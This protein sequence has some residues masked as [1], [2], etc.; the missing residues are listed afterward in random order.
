MRPSPSSHICAASIFSTILLFAIPVIARHNAAPSHPQSSQ[1]VLTYHVDNLRTGWFSSESQLNTSN[2]NPQS[3]GLLQ[4]VVLD[5]RVDAEPLVVMNQTI[6]GHG[7]HNVVYIATENNSVY[8]IDGDDGSILW[9]RAFGTPVPYQYKNSDDNVFPVMGILGTP[10]IDRV[11]GAMYFVS[12]KY[13]GKRDIFYLHAISLSTGKKLLPSVEIKF[14]QRLPSGKLWTLNPQVHLQRPGLLEVNGDLYIAF[15]STGDSDPDKSRG[16]ILRYDPATLTQLSGQLIN[17]LNKPASPYYLS[18]IWQSGYAPAAD[19]NGDVYFSTGNSDHHNPSYSDLNWPDSVVHLSGDLSTVVDSFTTHNYFQLDQKDLDTG[20][21]GT[22]LLPDQ[23]GSIPHL[24][25]A[26]GK[27]A[28][29]FLMNRDQLGSYTDNGPD[30][31]LQVFQKGACWCGPAYFVGSDGF[32]Y[33]VTGGRKGVISWQLQT[34]PAVLLVQASSTGPDVVSGLPH[35]GGTFPVVSSNGTVAGSGIVWFVQRSATSSDQDPGTPVTLYAYAAS[36]LTQQLVSLTSGT[37]THATNSDANLVP[38]VANGKVYVAS[39]KQLQI[40]G[41]LAA[42]K[43]SHPAAVPKS[44]VPSPPAVIECPPEQGRE[45]AGAHEF[46]GTICQVKGDELHLS[47]RS[48]RSIVLDA[49]RARTQEE[50]V[51]LTPGRPVRVNATID[52]K[53]G[54]YVERVFPSHMSSANTPPD[55]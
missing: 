36:D 35:N 54:A 25:V 9:Q 6:A 23:P 17:R 46:Y 15:G 39:N 42:R 51:L 2:V 12:D 49:S 44:L 19:S 11:A 20:S 26:G 21:G 14:S 16:T 43:L 48:G 32:P 45:A 29:A 4:A 7:V 22:L 38:T 8:A 13:T 34:S 31:V 55:R 53:G 52:A 24:V 5:G 28:R 18:S 33:V 1:D 10:V 41:L 37:W 27:D 30:N 47:L 3:F 50:P 40:F